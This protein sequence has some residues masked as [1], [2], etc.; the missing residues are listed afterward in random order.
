M[1]IFLLVV[2]N[3]NAQRNTVKAITAVMAQQTTAW[4]SGNLEAFMQTYWNNDS[5][6]FIGKN[7]VTYGWQNTLNNYIKSYP[8]KAAMGFLTFNLLK[9]QKLAK[10]KYN[11]VGNWRLKRNA[12]DVGGHF[13]LIFHKIKGKWLIVQDHSS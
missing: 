8:D 12:G 9:I 3:V 5:L 13:T 2:V 11:V 4:N 10:T 7:G 1:A 6:M